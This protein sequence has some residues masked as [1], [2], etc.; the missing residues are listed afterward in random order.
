MYLLSGFLLLLCIV[1]FF[2]NHRRKKC[3]IQKICRMDHCEKLRVLNDL[4]KP[5]GFTYI[6]PEDIMSSTLDAW[7]RGF[8]YCALYD[9]SAPGFNM[10][11]DCEPVY[12]SYE[13]RTWL[14]EFWKGQYGINIG[15]EIGVYRAD[16]IVPPEKRSAALFGS[17]PDAELLPLSMELFYRD[18]S[19][20]AARERHWWLT[21]FRMGAFAKPEELTMNCS[22]TFPNHCM[23]QS[24]V[25]GMMET[26]YGRCELNI[27]GLTV[28][29]RFDRPRTGQPRAGRRLLTWW[30]LQKNRLFCRVYRL[31]TRPFSRTQDKL[32]YLYYFLPAACRHM[33][34]LRRMPKR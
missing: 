13:N 2:L 12:F 1:F 27:C 28:T 8:G 20:F 26:G 21:G 34:R 10:V 22:V 33:L 23:L 14:M 30:A 29:F 4:A 7:Q 31:M 16:T 15:C 17:V 24:F 19:L 18:Q 25:E 3:I 32:L 6:C 11:Y 5:F 9:R